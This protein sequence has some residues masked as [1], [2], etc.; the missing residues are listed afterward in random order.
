MREK[1]AD[2]F[3]A[4]T[5]SI[6]IISF[7]LLYSVDIVGAVVIAVASVVLGIL[8]IRLD[9]DLRPPLFLSVG[10]LFSSAVSLYL[11]V[12]LVTD[13]TLNNKFIPVCLLLSFAVA[14]AIATSSGRASKSVAAVMSVL[15]VILLLVVFLLCLLESDFSAGVTVINDKKILLPI[16]VFSVIDTVFILPFVKKKNRVA[17]VFGGAVIPVYLLATVTLTL[18]VVPHN[19]PFVNPILKMWQTCFVLSF[20]DRFE[21]LI[22]CVIFSLSIVKAGIILQTALIKIPKTLLFIPALLAVFLILRPGLIYVFA[23][24]TFLFVIVYLLFKKN[25]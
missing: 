1:T 25:H 6:S 23:V 19:L 12:T 13:L 10:A 8:F 15:A 5:I 11:G 14:V 18:F 3:Y 7:S 24:L 16:I 9:T 17:C 21:T 22:I 20:I 4:F 2:F